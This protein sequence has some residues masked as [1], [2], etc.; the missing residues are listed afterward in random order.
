MDKMAILMEKLALIAVKGV[1]SNFE[2][3]DLTRIGQTA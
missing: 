2:L 3:Q 1:T